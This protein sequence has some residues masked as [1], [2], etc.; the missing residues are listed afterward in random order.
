MITAGADPGVGFDWDFFPFIG[1]LRD[2]A[3][4]VLATSLIVCVVIMALAAVAWGA[5]KLSGSRGVQSVGFS[6]FLIAAVATVGVG[7]ANGIAAWGSGVNTG[8]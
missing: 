8:F 4:G 1:A 6:V 2:A 3:G 5:G 7:A